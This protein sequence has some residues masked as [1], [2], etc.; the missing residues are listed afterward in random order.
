VVMGTPLRNYS[1]DTVQLAEEYAESAGKT[2]RTLQD[3]KDLLAE[4]CPGETFPGGDLHEITA[5]SIE[6]NFD[7]IEDRDDREYLKTLGTT[8]NLSGEAIDRLRKAARDVLLH[9]KEYEQLLEDL[10]A[11]PPSDDD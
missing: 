3:C 9:S 5:Y 2:Q 6:V 10:E 11:T 7:A 1:F 4:L 8:F